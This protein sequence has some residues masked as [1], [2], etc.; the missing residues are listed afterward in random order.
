MKRLLICCPQLQVF[1]D[2]AP[3]AVE[4]I[5]RSVL[6]SISIAP[7]L[8]TG[9]GESLRSSRSLVLNRDDKDSSRPASQIR[10]LKWGY[11]SPSKSDVLDPA[12]SSVIHS[13]GASGALPLWTLIVF[14]SDSKLHNAISSWLGSTLFI[15]YRQQ[16]YT[17]TFITKRALRSMSR[18]DHSV[19]RTI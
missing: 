8:L 3:Y 16:S 17:C 19:G 15:V 10:S 11:G 13:C 5:S 9:A 7:T 4:E 6:P 12:H 1:V 2:A 18:F 14:P